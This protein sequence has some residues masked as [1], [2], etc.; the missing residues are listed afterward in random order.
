ME[1][2]IV[3]WGYII[4]PIKAIRE[5][6]KYPRGLPNYLI[7]RMVARNSCRMLLVLAAESCKHG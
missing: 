4:S 2:T 1:T 6:I 3:Y 5:N 7:L